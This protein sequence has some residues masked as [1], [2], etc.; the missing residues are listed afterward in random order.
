LEPSADKDYQLSTYDIPDPIKESRKYKSH[1][2]KRLVDF[3]QQYQSRDHT[4][5][6]ENDTAILPVIQMGP[7]NIR[8]DEKLTLTLFELANKQTDW[9]TIHLTS[10]YFNFTEKY[11]A[12]ILKTK[13]KFR[14]LT[15]S[16]EVSK[17]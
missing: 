7:F 15:A 9:W 6:S 8:Q 3:I 17:V 11:K 1:V 10:G 14:F 4:S 2:N 16:P 5:E 12:F 13:A